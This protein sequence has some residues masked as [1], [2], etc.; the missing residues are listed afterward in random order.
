MS[1]R[2]KDITVRFRHAF[3][4]KGVERILPPGEYRATTE[5]DS[6]DGLSFLAYRRVSAIIV[7]PTHKDCA[8]EA[9]LDQSSS[10][11]VVPVGPRELERALERDAAL[12]TA[13]G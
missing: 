11:E 10:V 12:S 3:S 8:M 7:L 9:R 13:Q 4:L 2:T 5:E 1:T 6:I